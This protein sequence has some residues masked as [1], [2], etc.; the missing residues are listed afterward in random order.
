M[1]VLDL[2]QQDTHEWTEATLQH[3]LATYLHVCHGNSNFYALTPTPKFKLPSSHWL[4]LIV[5]NNCAKK[6]QSNSLAKKF[7]AAKNF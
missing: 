6:T 3:K 2:S 1:L 5:A 7:Q 4:S